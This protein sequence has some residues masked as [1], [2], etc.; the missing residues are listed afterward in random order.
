MLTTVAGRRLGP[1]PSL[2]LK[3]MRARGW[4]GIV[5]QGHAETLGALRQLGI[6]C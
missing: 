1:T 4:G 3:L 6:E 2:F 5:H